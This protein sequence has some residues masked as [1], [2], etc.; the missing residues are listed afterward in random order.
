MKAGRRFTD[1]ASPRSD[2]VGSD[3]L[4]REHSR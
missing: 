2:F 3:N 1:F 4:I